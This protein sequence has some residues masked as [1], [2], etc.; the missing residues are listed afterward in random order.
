M[1][2]E[3]ALDIDG[4]NVEELR[5]LYVKALGNE[6]EGIKTLYQSKRYALFHQLTPR[7]D[8]VFHI[9]AYKGSVDLLRVLFDMVAVHRKWDVL[10][11][12][13]IQGNTLLHEVAMSKNVEAAKFLV[14]IAHEGRARILLDCNYLGE[15]ALYR[16]AAFGNKATV[17][18]LAN[19]VEREGNLQDHFTRTFDGLS[20]LHNAIMNGK[21]ETAIWL[22]IKDPELA[23]QKYLEETCLQLLARMPT[24]F[25]SSS[26]K[27]NGLKEIIY[28][29]IP[30]NLPYRDETHQ[31]VPS[32]SSKTREHHRPMTENI[33][34]RMYDH[35]WL[36]LAKGW[37]LINEI[38]KTKKRHEFAV[39]LAKM[40]VKMDS[41]SRRE[42]C[43]LEGQNTIMRF[44]GDRKKGDKKK[45]EAL[46]QT[47]GV[48]IAA[49]TIEEI[50]D[51]PLIIA[52]STGIKEIVNE[53]IEVYP[54]AL[55]HVTRNGQ[56][57]LHVAILHRHRIFDG[58]KAE[59]EVRETVK[60]RLVLGIDNDGDTILHKAASAKYY[61]GGTTS[62][63]ALELREELR[64]FR[65]VEKLVP[66]H[67]KIHLNNENQTAEQLFKDQHKEQLKEAQ[68]WV[69]NTSQSCSTVAVLVATVVF[70]AAFTAPGGFRENGNPV[71]GDKPLYSFFT[72]MDVA[73]LAS[74]LTSV[75]LFLSVLTSS[76]DLGDFH[77]T[78]PRKLS[79]GFTCLFFAIANTVLSFTATI[80][81]T[82][83]LKKAWTTTLTYAA[84]FLPVSAYAI[85]QFGMYI[86]YLKSA[87]IS[88]F[89]LVKSFF[90]G[91]D[92]EYFFI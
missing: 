36:S 82:V 37:N 92:D 13:N 1:A 44:S 8:T 48:D 15:T 28:R 65:K 40:L 19:E 77:S 86:A 89:E 71:F 20:I 62:T 51:T 76:L 79:F 88:I 60:Q 72:V 30:G 80:I 14:E 87:F 81:L 32:Q 66:P 84:A 68:E 52:A 34:L 17:E 64:W 56:N 16:A 45:G 2:K 6:W 47:G 7:G 67:Y 22:L 31:H 59:K 73:G 9:A 74:S 63:A 27:M 46:S 23:M 11:M 12:K 57:I 85:V 39:K 35:F 10:T 49:A 53:I 58:I 61:R 90:E 38:G 55:E 83:H 42:H 18:Y 5:E 75:V 43:N 78:I 54:Q 26:P 4:E 41:S 3:V 24:A 50:P 91:Y 21:F 33:S 25:K 70:A 69:K 29:F